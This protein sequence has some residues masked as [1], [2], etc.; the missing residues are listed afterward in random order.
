MRKLRIFLR[1]HSQCVAELGCELRSELESHSSSHP[2]TLVLRD[3]AQRRDEAG[4]KGGGS[5]RARENKKAQ[6]E[7][8]GERTALLMAQGVGTTERVA[9]EL[10]CRAN[11]RRLADPP[12]KCCVGCHCPQGSPGASNL[13][14]RMGS[15]PGEVYR[16]PTLYASFS[17]SSDLP[18]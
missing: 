14:Q 13:R 15:L 3:S 17:S 8:R 10:V 7:R 1:P 6:G 9:H 18:K 2:I 4:R 12:F 5:Q 11:G 16:S